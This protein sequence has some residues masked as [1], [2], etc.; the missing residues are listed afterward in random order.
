MWTLFKRGMINSLR[1]PQ[2]I[3]LRFALYFMLALLIG[4]IWL[5]LGTSAKVRNTKKKEEKQN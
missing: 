3:W 2:V 1:A 4:T 5:L